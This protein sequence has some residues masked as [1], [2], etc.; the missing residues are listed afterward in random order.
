M[1]LRY[2]D[3]GLGGSGGLRREDGLARHTVSLVTLSRSSDSLPH[4]IRY[5]EASH[6]LV[7]ATVGSLARLASAHHTCRAT[8]AMTSLCECGDDKS[9]CG[10]M[11]L[12]L[13]LLCD[14]GDDEP[15]CKL[16]A[17]GGWG[18]AGGSVA[19][20]SLTVSCGWAGGSLLRIA[21]LSSDFGDHTTG[22]NVAGLFKAHSRHR[23]K[24]CG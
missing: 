12:S 13:S 2:S 8:V 22:H 6:R 3:G 5:A 4:A 23:V 24:V 18:W 15:D 7:I 16:R 21:Y 14:C 9:D 1:S 10:H 11:T 20:T 19:M 17:R